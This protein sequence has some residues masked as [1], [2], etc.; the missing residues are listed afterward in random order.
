MAIVSAD[1]ALMLSL[2]MPE[3]DTGTTGGDIDPDNRPVFTQMSADDSIEC[4]SSSAAD[5]M[6]I[7][8]FGR[9]AGG[10]I[11][12]E[13]KALTGTTFIT[14]ATMGSIERVL[15][16]QLASDAAGI[17]TVR[18]ATGDVLIADIP[19]AERGFEIMFYDASSDPSGTKV[20]YEK[21][22]W[23]NNHAT[24]TLTGA[25]VTLTAD[26]STK[27]DIRLEDAIND[28]NSAADRLT[29]PTGNGGSWTGLS[30]A[31]SLPSDLTA[32]SYIGTWIRQSLDAADS[33]IRATFDVKLAGSTTG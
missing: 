28:T 16:A 17:V 24:L 3:A 7:T 29:D 14:L 33:P 15:K 6:N 25:E 9:D 13:T 1:L 10:A 5:T 22:F 21:M 20:R 32:T 4:V 8:V 27:L 2:N 26:S 19:I 23:Q 31:I 18:R 12:S 30:T 11:V